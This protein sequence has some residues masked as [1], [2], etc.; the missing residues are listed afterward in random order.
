MSRQLSVVLSSLKTYPV[1]V[2]FKSG[3]M[4][5]QILALAL[6]ALPKAMAHGG[7]LAVAIGDAWYDGWQPYDTPVGQTSIIRPWS[8]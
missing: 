2:E 8:T 4:L 3:I 1:L 6:L 7:V 5:T